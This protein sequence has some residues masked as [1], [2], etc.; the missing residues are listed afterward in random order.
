[1]LVAALMAPSSADPAA[2]FF[3]NIIAHLDM[4]GQSPAPVCQAHL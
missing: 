3:Y 2:S 1:V 4:S